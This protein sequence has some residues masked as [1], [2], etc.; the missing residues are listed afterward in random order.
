MFFSLYFNHI[1]KCFSSLS[2]NYVQVLQKKIDQQQKSNYRLA[3]GQWNAFLRLAISQHLRIYSRL[4]Q[5]LGT[6]DIQ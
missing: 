3:G 1:A 6:A 4:V 2:K 5:R